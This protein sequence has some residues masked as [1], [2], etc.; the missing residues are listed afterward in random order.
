MKA[1]IGFLLL[2]SYPALAINVK[3]CHDRGRSGWFL[4]LSAI[5][6][7]GLWV[8]VELYLLGGTAGTNQYGEES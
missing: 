8:A 6:L 7:I 1:V 3:R 5:P 4:L 2:T